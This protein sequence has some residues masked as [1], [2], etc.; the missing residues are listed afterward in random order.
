MWTL[1]E[2]VDL[3]LHDFM[4]YFAATWLNNRM[5][6]QRAV[7]TETDNLNYDFCIITSDKTGP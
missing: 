2:A 3:Y 1:T 6:K 7:Q 4:H 5:N